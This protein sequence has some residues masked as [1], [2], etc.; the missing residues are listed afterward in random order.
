MIKYG[1]VS[2]CQRF[3]LMCQEA[4]CPDIIDRRDPIQKFIEEGAFE[5]ESLGQDTKGEE[6]YLAHDVLT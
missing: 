6:E 5:P 4:F 3:L 1:G 2:R